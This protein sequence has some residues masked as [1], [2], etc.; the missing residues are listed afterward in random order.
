MSGNVGSERRVE[1]TAVGDATNVAARIEQ[2]TKGTPHQLL[3][4]GATKE[5][6]VEPP[7]DLLFVEEVEV[8]GRRAHITVWSLPERGPAAQSDDRTGDQPPTE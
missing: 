5:A 8:R 3:L 6:L 4:S 7:D 2:L 1:Y